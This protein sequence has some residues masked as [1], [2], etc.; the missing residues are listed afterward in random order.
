MKLIKEELK[1]VSDNGLFKV[2]LLLSIPVVF[3][4]VL[5]LWLM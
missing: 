3:T 1:N 5:E 4:L 2:A